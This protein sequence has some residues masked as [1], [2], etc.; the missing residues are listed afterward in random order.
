MAPFT[1]LSRETQIQRKH[2]GSFLFRPEDGGEIILWIVRDFSELHRIT[3]QKTKLLKCFAANM[4]YIVNYNL[5]EEGY[6]LDWLW[7]LV[8]YFL[9]FLRTSE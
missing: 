8:A 6:I 3:A 5:R 2:T 9:I 1:L 4:L 7:L